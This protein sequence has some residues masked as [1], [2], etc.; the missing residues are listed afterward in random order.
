MH[1][2]IWLYIHSSSASSLAELRLLGS[3]CSILRINRK[4]ATLSDVPSRVVSFF[5]SG[6]GSVNKSGV[7]KLPG[8]IGL[9]DLDAKIY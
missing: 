1:I 6:A 8:A 9:V 4:K 5:A 2:Y 3:H 7:R